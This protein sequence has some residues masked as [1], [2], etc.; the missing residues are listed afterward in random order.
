MMTVVAT[1]N[2][3]TV[4][5]SKVLLSTFYKWWNWSLQKL[6]NLPEDPWLPNVRSEIWTKANC[7]ILAQPRNKQ[8]QRHSCLWLLMQLEWGQNGVK[9]N[10]HIWNFHKVLMPTWYSRKNTGSGIIKTWIPIL[11]P[12]L[13]N[14]LDLTEDVPSSTNTEGN[15]INLR[16]L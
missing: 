11:D 8:E 2:T 1:A 13:G 7:L 15:H 6:S 4:L 5:V 16:E 12:S 3:F 14:L 10:F 9:W